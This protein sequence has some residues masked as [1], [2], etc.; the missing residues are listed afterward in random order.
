[1]LR[2]DGYACFIHR[3]CVDVNKRQYFDFFY[4]NKL[5][6]PDEVFVHMGCA[7][8]FNEKCFI[9]YIGDNY[10][11]IFTFEPSPAQFVKCEKE[12][13]NL[14]DCLVVNKG[15]ADKSETLSLFEPNDLQASRI[16]DRGSIKVEV[17]ALDEYCKNE[18]ITFIAMDIE[19][20]ELKAFQ[21]A[22][23]IITTHK[24]KL[25]VSIYHKHEDIYEIPHYIKQLNPNYKLALRLYG[26]NWMD[27]CICYAY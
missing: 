22:H 23:N 1:M 17:V 15:C 27:D 5:F 2:S 24:P 26:K 19:G 21:G 13:A 8:G 25:A 4:E 12:L 3:E 11:K 18:K 16:S 7:D 14:R 10:K 9:E 20:Y 6:V